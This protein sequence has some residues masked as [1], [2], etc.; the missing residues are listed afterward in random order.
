[1]FNQPIH[2]QWAV[3]S[4]VS[5]FDLDT[6]IRKISFNKEKVVGS[7]S[8]HTLTMWAISPKNGETSDVLA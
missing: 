3:A 7:Y 5:C 4:P 8:H 2:Q 6:T 1:M